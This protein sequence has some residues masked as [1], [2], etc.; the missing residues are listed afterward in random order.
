MEY[1]DRE[2]LTKRGLEFN[3]RRC[4][5]NPNTRE[6]SDHV[7]RMRKCYTDRWDYTE[8]DGVAFPLYVVPG[9]PGFGFCPGKLLR[10]DDQ[11]ALQIFNEL[12]IIVRSKTWP[13][14]GGLFDQEVF[15]VELYREFEPICRDLEFNKRF[16]TVA[17]AVESAFGGSGGNAPG[18]NTLP[19]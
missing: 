17:K 2:E 16:S 10:G 5:V 1:A 14:E 18:Q 4:L 13:I 6:P 12:M 7:A 15:W 9:G 8:R 11:L 3:C 19:R